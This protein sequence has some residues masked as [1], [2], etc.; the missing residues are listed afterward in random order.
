M[1]PGVTALTQMQIGYNDASAASSDKA[2]SDNVQVNASV[3]EPSSWPPLAPTM[4]PGDSRPRLV[5]RRSG[6]GSTW[7]KY[8]AW[9]LPGGLWRGYVPVGVNFP[10]ASS[11]TVTCPRR[12]IKGTRDR[13]PFSVWIFEQPG[14]TAGSRLAEL[15]GRCWNRLRFRRLATRA[16][17][18]SWREDQAV[19]LRR[20]TRLGEPLGEEAFIARLERQAGRR[21]RVWRPGRPQRAASE[22]AVAQGLLFEE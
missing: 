10:T 11:E 22:L 19:S 16:S 9:N 8:D 7:R 20:G 17:A 6:A 21:L 15:D 4:C 18:R 3:H 12:R 13:R 14:R 2:Y 1:A 5:R